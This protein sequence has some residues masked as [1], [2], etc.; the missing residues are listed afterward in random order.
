VEYLSV[1]FWC[2]Y[3]STDYKVSAE[4]YSKISE[5]NHSKFGYVLSCLFGNNHVFFIFRHAIKQLIL[6]QVT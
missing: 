1:V 4:A 2:I 5:F 3:K 6:T